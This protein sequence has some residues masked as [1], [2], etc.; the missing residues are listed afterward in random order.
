[1][2]MLL[3]KDKDKYKDKNK[4][5][6]YVEATTWKFETSLSLAIFNQ[7]F[8]SHAAASQEQKSFHNCIIG[9]WISWADIYDRRLRYM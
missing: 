4:D 3:D 5:N 1:M 7:L 2:R 6:L 8:S 9:S